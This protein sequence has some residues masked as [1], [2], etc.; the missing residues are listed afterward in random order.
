MSPPRAYR[1]ESNH[2]MYKLKTLAVACVAM[3][4]AVTAVPTRAGEGHDHGEAPSTSGVP[5][6][7]RFAAVS[8]S[9]ELVGVLKDRPLTLYLDRTS[10]NSPV[11]G[12]T[13]TLEVQGVKVEVK[14]TGE[15]EFEAMLAQVPPP[16]FTA[17]TATIIAGAE[18]D[19]LAGELDTR[20]A[21]ATAHA[22]IPSAWSRYG[23]WAAG[24]LLLLIALAWMLRR[25][26]ASQH[27]RLGGTA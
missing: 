26:R 19:L 18:T 25:A 7:P 12:A 16:G 21:A 6:L 14:P 4:L 1:H 8:E 22:A 13:L 17:I 10:D 23:A 2:N 5:S 27:H 24:A 20:E 15:G 11:K 3:L 9:F